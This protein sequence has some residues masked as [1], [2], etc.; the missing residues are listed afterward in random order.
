MQIRTEADEAALKTQSELLSG[1][2]GVEPHIARRVLEK[3][4]GNVEK[5]ADALLS[6]DRGLEDAQ[7]H[8][9]HHENLKKH[10]TTPEPSY[11]E[12][13]R[14]TAVGPGPSANLNSVASTSGVVDLTG[15]DEDDPQL[16]HAMELSM[17][18]QTTPQFQR[19]DRAPDPNWQM[20]RSNVRFVHFFKDR[21]TCLL[22][23]LKEPIGPSAAQQEEQS[24]HEAIQASLQDLPSEADS[25][26]YKAAVREGGRCVLLKLLQG[27][28]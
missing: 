25:N 26:P 18:S 24:I 2:T 27:I 23:F 16:R 15:E 19:S 14:R 22:L 28:L 20:V 1:I 5:A 13:G 12:S 3:Y 9:Q 21:A 6:G 10:R 8:P 17:G 4:G 7:Q 11:H